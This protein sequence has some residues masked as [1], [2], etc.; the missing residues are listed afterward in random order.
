ME[1]ALAGEWVRQQVK[2]DD[3]PPTY[4]QMVIYYRQHQDEFTTPTRAQYEELMVRYDK[5]PDKAAAWDAIA[6]MGNRVWHG[7]PFAEVAKARSDGATAAE[8]GRRDWTSKGS[9]VCA[10]LDQALFTLPVGQLSPIIEGPTGFHIVR[11]TA[12]E[13]TAI[14]PFLEAQ[15]NIKKNIS[16]A[17]SKKEF[18]DYMAK[19]E[20][21]T[22]VWTKYDND[23]PDAQTAARPQEPPR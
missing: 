2:H 11:V 20:A 19:L 16:N 9:L 22:P 21:R 17:Q 10:A 4:D 8:G 23:R 6:E 12:R 13:E 15:V 1:N 14:R 5:F 7:T 18:K 3:D